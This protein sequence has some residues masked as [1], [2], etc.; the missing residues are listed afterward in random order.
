MKKAI[1]IICVLVV[2]LV[3]AVV[4]LSLL[5]GDSENGTKTNNVQNQKETLIYED[6]TV[7]VWYLDDAEEK[8][9][10]EGMCFFSLRVE[11]KTDD[12]ITFYP[13]DASVDGNMVTVSSGVPLALKPQTK[14]TNTF[15]INYTSFASDISEL[16]QMEFSGM[17]MSESGE[18]VYTGS[19]SFDF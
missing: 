5:G 19:I 14:G 9:S 16:T 15:F 10:Y 3:V 1:R 12:A 18:T 2:L 4:C 7:S 17:I 13:I 11:N 6:D 8:E